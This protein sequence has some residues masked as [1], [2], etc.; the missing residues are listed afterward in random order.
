MKVLAVPQWS[1]GRDRR[2]LADCRDAMLSAPVDT[3]Y[4]E[5]DIDHNRSV[6]AF[7]GELEDVKDLLLAL[8]GMIL[9]GIDLNRH[10]GVHP[11]LGALDVCPFTPL[12]SP[13][14]KLR[15]QKFKEWIETVGRS[16]AEEFGV[17]VF[18][19]ERSERGRSES[20]IANLRN[21]GFGGLLDKDLQPD[22]GPAALHPH[23][24]VTL[25]GWRDF[26]ITLNV[27][28][29]SGNPLAAQRIAQRIRDMRSDGDPRML[30]VKALGV[31]LPTREMSQVCLAMTLPDLTP[32]DPILEYVSVAADSLGADVAFTELV[33]VIR[34]SD[35]E[36][37]T[38]VH[39][40]PEQIVPMG[41]RV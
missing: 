38:R 31:P 1:F 14:T 7:S 12:E 20:E 2:L 19:Y 40:R 3:H 17:P 5:S 39:P 32:V 10:V 8:A 15:L 41:V 26:V 6:T 35:L 13:K 23:S 33:G 25:M 22:F 4:C 16:F 34:T 29:S 21:G 37:A 30:G 11:R 9:P 18:L 36:H 24:G 28:L 27:N